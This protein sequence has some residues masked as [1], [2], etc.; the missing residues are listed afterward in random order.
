M[1]LG[2]HFHVPA[3][4]RDGGVFVP[5]FI[6]GW[7]DS[8]AS[9]CEQVICFLHS[10]SSEEEVLMDY[11]L[12][13]PNITLVGIGPHSSVPRRLLSANKTKKIIRQWSHNIDVMLIRGPSPL[14]P[15]VALACGKTPVVLM[16]VADYVAGVSSL[17]QPRWRKEIIRLWSYWNK[18]Q[19]NRVAE[20][21]LTLVN[22]R[23]LYN[24]MVSRVSNLIEIRTTT[25]T[26]DNF[27]YR[28]DTCQRMPFK[29]LTTG[30]MSRSKGILNVLDAIAEL[31]K[32]GEDI[33][34]DL[35]GMIEK[36]D[37]VL[38]ELAKK[39]KAYG[40]SDRVR[41]HGYHPAGSELLNYY[42]NSDIFVV[43]SKSSAEGF[44]RTIWEAFSQGTPVIAT[45]VSSIPYFLKDE[46]DALIVSPNSP[47]ELA[48][49]IKRLISEPAL[50]KKLIANGYKLAEE[51]TLDRRAKE[52]ITEI[53]NW[54]ASSK[55]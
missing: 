36:G 2:F 5:S 51:N 33:H 47:S 46:Q 3:I 24:Q 17:P 55:S 21:T 32:Q 54:L 1:R 12:Q 10:P 11:R 14:L 7:L 22:S 27:F 40:I 8:I 42:K 37:P 34:F 25:L 16:L 6:G 19:Q 41:Y 4:A 50:R 20:N 23:L 52:M 9:N 53:E 31:I 49:S 48:M 29:I 39:A 18:F 35:V 38:D 28:E 15:Q 30:R 43:A 13:S 44:P 45:N 26:K